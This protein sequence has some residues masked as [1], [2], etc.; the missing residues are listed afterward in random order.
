LRLDTTFTYSDPERLIVYRA[1]DVITG[2]LS[3][4]RPF[5]VGGAQIQ[6]SF[7]LRPDL[8]TI[9]LAMTSGSAAVPSVADVYI[10]N[11]K[12]YSQAVDAGPYQITNIPIVVGGG[13]A[14]VILSDAAGH[15]IQTALPFYTSPSLLAPGLLSFS[16]EAGLPRNAFGTTSDA[17]LGKE[18][19][20]AS[21]RKGIYD[22]LTVESHVEAGAG[23]AN[24]GAGVV[25]RAGGFGVASF[26]VAASRTGAVHGFQPFGSF[27]TKLGPVTLSA[28]S[29]ATFGQ[30][31][32]VAAAT[33]R[34]ESG[35]LLRRGR[36]LGVIE[37]VMPVWGNSSYYFASSAPPKTL[38][39]ISVGA[40]LPLD[41]GSISLSYIGA[42]SVVGDRSRI[43][44][45]TYSRALPYSANFNATA[46][47][48][49]G[50]HKSAGI[51]AGLSVPI[52]GPAVA[53]IGM[54]RTRDGS[55]VVADL[56]QPLG[57]EPGSMGWRLSG[58]EGKPA[59]QLAGASYRSGYGWGEVTAAHANGTTGATAQI[60]GSIATMGSGIFF[61]NRIDD[62]FAVVETG[63]PGVPVSYENRPAGRTDNS[64]R[65]LVPGLR[66][67]QSNKVSIDTTSLPVDADL[68]KTEEYVAPADRSGVR[69]DFSV[70]TNTNS[71]ILV[72][73]T[74][75]GSPVPAGARGMVPGRS[76]T[77]IVGYDGRAYLH[78]L[79]DENVVSVETARGRCEASFT[80]TPRANEQVSIPVTC[81]Y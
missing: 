17:Y 66:S 58:I 81:R 63:H 3:W 41:L 54:S 75:D 71:A 9:P 80:Y 8:V 32:D 70:R 76:E 10:N 60:D 13:D 48:D 27:E 49:F 64:G 12:T 47:F 42:S 46:F 38:N 77:F 67:Y 57:A 14:R 2:G 20:S 33:G 36:R 7:A 6:R 62:A 51:W 31:D 45:A 39:K 11:V 68:G 72:L 34:I 5:R 79:S 56:S 50:N 78:G 16:A 55:G 73:R 4:T 1:G 65:L 52:G 44:T 15:Q 53:S 23:T 59:S 74:L 35:N 22:W 25:V 61:G 30:Y 69:L 43:V 21:L 24:T 26:A 19:A 29:Q 40:P 37:L 28:S 18:V